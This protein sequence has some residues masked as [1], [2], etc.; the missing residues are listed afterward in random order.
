[1][2][3]RT[4]PGALVLIGLLVVSLGLYWAADTGSGAIQAMMLV[5][6]SLIALAAVWVWR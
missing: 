6:L 4:V 1:M 3:R 5:L 2:N